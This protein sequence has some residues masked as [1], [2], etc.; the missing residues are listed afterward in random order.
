MDFKAYIDSGVLELY[1]SGLL[2]ETEAQQVEEYAA[3]YPEVQQEIDAIRSS[4]NN[5]ARRSGRAPRV[6]DDQAHER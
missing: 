3:H 4:V 5:Y 6:T 2:S 1:V